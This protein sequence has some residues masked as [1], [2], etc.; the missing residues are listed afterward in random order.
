MLSA[1]RRVWSTG[2]AEDILE[3]IN[4]ANHDEH[5]PDPAETEVVDQ[6]AVPCEVDD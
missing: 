2:E 1:R 6:G 4:I 3:K 5:L